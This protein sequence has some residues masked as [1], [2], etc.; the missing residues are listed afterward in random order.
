MEEIEFCVLIKHY[1][2]HQK[3]IK[4][5]KLKW[6]NIIWILLH[7]ME[8]FIEFCC[9]QAWMKLSGLDVGTR[10]QLKFLTRHNMVHKIHVIT[11]YLVK[12]H[13]TDQIVNMSDKCGFNILHEHLGREKLLSRW[14]PYLLTIDQKLNWST[15]SKQCL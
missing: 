13:K 5:I 6:T 12:V 3:I 9:S 7:P 2:F 4:E 14:V 1:F 11:L 10:P 15:I 8:W